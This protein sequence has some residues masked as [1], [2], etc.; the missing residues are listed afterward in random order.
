[1]DKSGKK[2]VGSVNATLDPDDNDY[3]VTAT[4]DKAFSVNDKSG[5]TTKNAPN[6]A[7]SDFNGCWTF[8]GKGSFA[9]AALGCFQQEGDRVT[10]EDPVFEGLVVGNTLRFTLKAGI[11][12][13][14]YAFHSGRFLM[15]KDGEMFIGSVNRSLNPDD[16]D[17][18]VTATLDKS[19]KRLSKD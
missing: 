3:P 11:A 16:N 7:P 1:M 14:A 10:F 4:F 6:V 17:Y 8:A 13:T 19:F 18:Q 5:V 15:D 2:F 12:N 9:R